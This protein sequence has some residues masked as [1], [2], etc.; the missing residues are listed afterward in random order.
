MSEPDQSQDVPITP[1]QDPLGENTLREE[2]G[3]PD[4][5]SPEDDAAPAKNLG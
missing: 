2:P 4:E 1:G 5:P 3:K